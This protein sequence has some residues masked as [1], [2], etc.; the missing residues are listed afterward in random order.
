MGNEKDNSIYKKDNLDNNEPLILLSN[1]N[2]SGGKYSFILKKSEK[3]SA[4][5]YKLTE[6]ISDRDEI[7]W[8]IRELS[9]R[10]VADLA[11]ESISRS[12]N[13]ASVLYN[14]SGALAALTSL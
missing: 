11:L 12:Y 9:S 8:D 10:I 1:T 5:L 6:F 14:T 7:K 2:I 13:K 4:V 3:L